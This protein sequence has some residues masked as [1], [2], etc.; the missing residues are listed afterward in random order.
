MNPF[1]SQCVFGKDAFMK[2][3]IKKRV[4]SYLLVG[5]VVLE[6][7]FGLSGCTVGDSVKKMAQVG[8]RTEDIKKTEGDSGAADYPVHGAL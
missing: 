1:R 5:A 6:V 8:K 2:N 7:V 4:C 3:R